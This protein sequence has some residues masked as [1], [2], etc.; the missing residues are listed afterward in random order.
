M[1][2]EIHN[3]SA[4]AVPFRAIL[5]VSIIPFCVQFLSFEDLLVMGSFMIAVCMFI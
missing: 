1:N 4:N 3:N 2:P 5:F